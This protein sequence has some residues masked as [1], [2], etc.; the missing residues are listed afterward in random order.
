MFSLFYVYLLPLRDNCVMLPSVDRFLSFSVVELAFFFN[1]LCYSCLIKIPSWGHKD[2]LLYRGLNLCYLQLGQSPLNHT[3]GNCELEQVSFLNLFL[4]MTLLW[5]YFLFVPP[6]LMTLFPFCAPV[7][8]AGSLVLC[9]G[10]PLTW[11][12]PVFYI[13]YSGGTQEAYGPMWKIW[14]RKLILFYISLLTTTK[15]SI[16]LLESSFYLC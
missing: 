5:S 12:L 10:P 16:F 4:T 1:G 3:Y 6:V 14:S 9:C 8:L 11:L 15:S 2:M 7:L 13:D